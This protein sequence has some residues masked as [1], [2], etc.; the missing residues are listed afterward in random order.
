MEI[1][2]YKKIGRSNQKFA[3]LLKKNQSVLLKNLLNKIK[4]MTKILKF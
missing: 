2:K 3:N 4:N 1:R